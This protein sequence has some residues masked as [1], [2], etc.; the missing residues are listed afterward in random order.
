MKTRFIVQRKTDDPCSMSDHGLA[1]IRL[2][3]GEVRF[4]FAW[5][6]C[7]QL[8]YFDVTLRGKKLN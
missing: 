5:S 8:L 2:D 7:D 6:N 4:S 1:W 3:V